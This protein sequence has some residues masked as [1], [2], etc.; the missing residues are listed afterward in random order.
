MK[1]QKKPESP[2]LY[3]YVTA[4]NYEIKQRGTTRKND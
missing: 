3:G 1:E 4:L 2:K